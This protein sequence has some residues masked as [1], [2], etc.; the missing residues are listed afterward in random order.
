MRKLRKHG[1]IVD[2]SQRKQDGKD[3][4]SLIPIMDMSEQLE[5]AVPFVHFAEKRFLCQMIL[6]IARTV[7]QVWRK[8]NESRIDCFL[9]VRDFVFDRLQQAT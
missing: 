6:I 1:I 9:S 3:Q 8:R 5:G 7:A 4:I 2:M